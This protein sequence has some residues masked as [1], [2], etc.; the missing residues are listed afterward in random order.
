MALVL[1]RQAEIDGSAAGRVNRKRRSPAPKGGEDGGMKALGRPR[2]GH[3]T[4][5]RC[6]RRF[7]LTQPIVPKFPPSDLQPSK[8]MAGIKQ[9]RCSALSTLRIFRKSRLKPLFVAADIA[10]VTVAANSRIQ[11]K[12][13][14]RS[15][16]ASALQRRRR[17][18]RVAPPC[19][20]RCQPRRR[21]Y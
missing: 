10:I 13:G 15:D 12:V 1:G 21:G 19:W 4:T 17:E 5:G 7:I 11:Q 9:D 8:I 16:K 2:K 3:T 14:R 6:K 20:S 18:R